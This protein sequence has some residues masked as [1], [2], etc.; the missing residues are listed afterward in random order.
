MCLNLN[1]AVLQTYSGL[2]IICYRLKETFLLQ[3]PAKITPVL[4]LLLLLYFL[5][6]TNAR[7][8]HNS[9]SVFNI[10]PVP[11]VSHSGVICKQQFSSDII[12]LHWWKCE[13]AD[14]LTCLSYHCVSNSKC[15]SK[16][17]Y[18]FSERETCSLFVCIQM[19]LVYG[20]IEESR[21]L[22]HGR[23][24]GQHTH[25][26]PTALAR[27]LAKSQPGLLV[28]AVVALHE[29]NKVQLEQADHLFKVCVC[30]FYQHLVTQLRT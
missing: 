7:I 14:R 15:I 23:G 4:W 1:I 21:L 30:V 6:K 2:H 27:Q 3:A 9:C 10:L 22:L 20:F 26:R 13:Q 11:P 24:G 8:R 12:K 28:A 17:K 18:E 19:L 16:C 25:I 5:Y 29:N